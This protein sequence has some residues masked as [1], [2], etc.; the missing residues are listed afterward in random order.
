MARTSVQKKAE[1]DKTAENVAQAIA[2]DTDFDQGE[3]LQAKADAAEA[4]KIQAEVENE[5]LKQELEELKAAKAENESTPASSGPGK[6]PPKIIETDDP[7]VADKYFKEGKLVRK[8]GIGTNA[9][10]RIFTQQD[11]SEGVR[12]AMKE[13]PKTVKGH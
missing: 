2:P 5:R 7:K 4:A 1:V 12:R 8:V 10:Y 6:R 3:D 11:V 13:V 9:K